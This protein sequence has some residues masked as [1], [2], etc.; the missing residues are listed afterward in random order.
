MTYRPLPDPNEIRDCDLESPE[1]EEGARLV[2]CGERQLR[3]LR[4]MGDV[5]IE[6]VE[7]LGQIAMSG[8]GPA[9]GD[10]AATMTIPATIDSIAGAYVKLTQSLR[11]TLAMETR[12]SD[13]LKGRRLGV[14]AARQ[15]QDAELIKVV[16]ECINENIEYAMTKAIRRERPDADRKTNERLLIDMFERL[17]DSDEFENYRELPPGETIAKLC[18]AFGLDPEFC[19]QAD[20]ETWMIRHGPAD[21]P[22]SNLRGG[23][24]AERVRVGPVTVSDAGVPPHEPHP[25]GYAVCPSP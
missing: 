4:R 21:S 16:H 24:D 10:G 12:L 7:R 13:E 2:E 8:A 3:M 19:I 9:S 11:R 17:K 15:A 14:I 22:P 20:D 23:T 6:L 1:M 18:A 5:G 25:D